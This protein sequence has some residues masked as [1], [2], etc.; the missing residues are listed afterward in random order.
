[1]LFCGGLECLQV[2]LCKII[3]RCS[4]GIY[5][6]PTLMVDIDI[7]WNYTFSSGTQ[8]VYKFT[9][10]NEDL[11]DS[12]TPCACFRRI[13]MPVAHFYNN[14]V[15]PSRQKQ[16]TVLQA[17]DYTTMNITALR[18]IANEFN[19]MMIDIRNQWVSC[20]Y[21]VDTFS[22]DGILLQL[23]K[24]LNALQ[25]TAYHNRVFLDMFDSSFLS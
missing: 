2:I 24:E 17:S 20:N 4:V 21:F 8:I 11:C 7:A 1:M 23:R 15:K 18:E 13:H 14:Y 10:M 19:I 22:Y 6:V 25:D 16:C 3:L 9:K 5:V 12:A